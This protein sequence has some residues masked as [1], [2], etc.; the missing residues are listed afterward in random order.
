MK[1]IIVDTRIDIAQRSTQ[2]ESMTTTKIFKSGNSLAVRLPREIA[3]A[4]GCPVTV[5]RQG[6]SLIIRPA[7]LDMATLCAK[8]GAAP[9]PR[10]LARL[11]AR[12]PRRVWNDLDA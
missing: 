12:P 3:F 11:D 4:E 8:L 9:A 5:T 2:A 1:R 10:P 6:D 7:R